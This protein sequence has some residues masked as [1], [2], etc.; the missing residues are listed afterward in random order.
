M[1]LNSRLYHM[2]VAARIQIETRTVLWPQF[3]GDNCRGT[4]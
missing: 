4:Y 1:M 2:L 3:V